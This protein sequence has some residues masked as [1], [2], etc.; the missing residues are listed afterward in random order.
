MRLIAI[1][2]ARVRP[3]AQ[4]VS[5]FLA[6][7]TPLPSAI[8]AT[9][10]P[11]ATTGTS[12]SPSPSS[13]DKQQPLSTRILTKASDF[14]LALG[15]DGEDGKK[16]A[17]FDW[18]RKTYNLGEKL[19]DRIEYE[20]WALKAVD[21]SLGPDVKSVVT[22]AQDK[23]PPQESIRIHY[24]PSLISP[25]HLIS[26]INNLAATRAPHHRSRMIA[27]V[28]G[29]PFT[30]PFM[31]VP[32]VPNL[33]FFYLVWRAWSHYKA[34]QSSIYLSSLLSQNRIIPFSD[35][36]IDAVFKQ[37]H[38]S[39]SPDAAN[40]QLILTPE[41]IQELKTV[42]E[43][44]QQAQIELTR[45]WQQTKASIANGQIN[46]LEAAAEGTDADKKDQ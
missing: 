4:P 30:I 5:T 45:A 18:K 38:S 8:P 23:P 34:Y 21:P 6:Q 36:S 42:L 15:R 40:S 46:K 1:P 16:L 32:V 39:S 22:S 9:P 14:W 25:E 10:T 27:C 17:V 13:S 28:I 3:G 24:P 37:V 20:E 43:L 19:M 12:S 29:M 35:T 41:H 2:L 44:N 26:N 33:P 11:T 31:L 7:R